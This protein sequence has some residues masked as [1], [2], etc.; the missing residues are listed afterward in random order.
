MQ[1]EECRNVL[2]YKLNIEYIIVL[3]GNVYTMSYTARSYKIF[4]GKKVKLTI[5]INGKTIYDE[6]VTKE[7]FENMFIVIRGENYNWFVE[8]LMLETMSLSKLNKFL[9]FDLYV[10]YRYYIESVLEEYKDEWE[11]LVRNK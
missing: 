3:F 4:K 8:N 2:G 1:I 5:E 11:N 9:Y 7:E 6:I 10:M